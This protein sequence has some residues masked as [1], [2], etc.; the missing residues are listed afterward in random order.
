MV[1]RKIKEAILGTD[2]RYEA[3]YYRYSQTKLENTKLR[4]KHKD[5]LD[6]QKEKID[7][8]SAKNLIK[9]AESIEITKN[10]SFKVNSLDKNVQRLLID[11]NTTQKLVNEMMKRLNLESVSADEEMYDP[12]MHEIASYSDA[13]G[14]KE[15]IIIKTIKKGYKLNGEIVKKPRI[16]VTK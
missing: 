11:V 15:G 2:D 10:D 3:L 16:C 4:N 14:M 12:Q 9:I 1:L 13:K 5:E 8:E 6:R 7:F